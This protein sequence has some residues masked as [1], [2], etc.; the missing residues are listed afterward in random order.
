MPSGGAAGDGSNLH[1]PPILDDMNAKKADPS[2]R[3]ADSH[4]LICVQGAEQE[5]GE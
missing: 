1:E 4:D 5:K 2:G 3:P